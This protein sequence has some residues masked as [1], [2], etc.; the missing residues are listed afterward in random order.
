MIKSIHIKKFKSISDL[1]INLSDNFNVLIGANNIGKTTV[2]EAIHL[3][4]MCY[5]RNLKK[6][7]DGFYANCCNIPFRDMES[8]R[9]YHDMDLFPK[10][11]PVANASTE[12]VLDLEYNSIIYSLGFRITKVASMDDVYYKTEY[13]DS[14]QFNNFSDMVN[15]VQGKNLSNFLVI[16]EA[17]PVAHVIAKEPYMYRDQVL[18]KIAKGKSNEVLRNKIINHISSVEEHINHVMG[19]NC[20]IT[21]ANKEDKTYISIKVDGKDIF[22]YGSGFIQL[23]EI[24]SSIE[25]LDA[26]IHLLLIDEPDAHLHVKLQKRLIDELRHMPEC[27]LVVISHNER[28]LSEVDESEILFINDISKASGQIEPLSVGSK[29]IVQENLTGCLGRE[30]ELRYASLLVIVEGQSDID[31]LESIRPIYEQFSGASCTGRVIVKMDGIDTLNGK[32]I[33]YSR[34]FKGLI[35]TECKWLIIRDTDCVPLS[36][37][38]SAWSIDKKNVD[39]GG[40][41]IDVCFQNGYGIESTFVAEPEKFSRLLC[42]Y[43]GLDDTEVS[44]VKSKLLSLNHDYFERVQKITDDI[45]IELKKHFDRQKRERGGKVYNNLELKD[46]LGEL[47]EH[48]VQHIMTKEIF[49]MYLADVHQYIQNSYPSITVEKLDHKSIF[50]FYYSWISSINDVLDSHIQLLNMIYSM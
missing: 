39:T 44:N 47:S 36:K 40:G 38:N 34:A 13:I 9:V 7:K 37:K 6:K 3:W 5:D 33:S 26:E 4:K 23:A 11:C 32:L 19:E 42:S 30:D 31:F 25:Y 22:S 8:I 49:D 16:S 15:D 29:G 12:I 45:S 21:E 17:R 43:Y 50:F 35:P 2:F 14:P 18:D 1:K 41:D 46:M 48:T 20:K 28:F 10:G 27:Q 24:F